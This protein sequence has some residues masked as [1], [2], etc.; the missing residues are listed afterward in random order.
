MVTRT[1]FPSLALSL[2][3]FAVDPFLVA[4]E[5]E[6]VTAGFLTNVWDRELAARATEVFQ[7]LPAPAR[8]YPG[9]SRAEAERFLLQDANY[10]QVVREKLAGR[11]F[12]ALIEASQEAPFAI[13]HLPFDFLLL[14]ACPCNRPAGS[15][16]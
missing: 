7:Q 2:A 16:G 1:K 9:L 13:D 10:A 5:R 8:H 15:T 4:A 14:R 3:L 11:W 6:Q 12:A